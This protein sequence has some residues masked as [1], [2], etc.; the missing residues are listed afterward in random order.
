ML[1]D[2]Y[3]INIM[4]INNQK[5]KSLVLL[6]LIGSTSAKK[7]N[8]SEITLNSLPQMET[9][10]TKRGNDSSQ[11]LIYAGMPISLMSYSLDKPV[12]ENAGNCTLGF[13]INGVAL[14]DWC[15]AVGNSF[16]TSARCC[17]KH[18]HCFSFTVLSPNEK[19]INV[20]KVQQS[21]YIDTSGWKRINFD[22]LRMSL[23]YLEED[24]NKVRITPYVMGGDEDFYP[25]IGLGS[26]TI[27]SQVCAYGAGSGYLCGKLIEI[28]SS[29]EFIKEG[30]NEN[31]TFV[32]NKVDLGEGHG[33]DSERD[34]GGPVYV[35]NTIG[36]T[37]VAQALGYISGVD[38]SDL[39]HKIFYYTPLS[40]FFNYA[41]EL[42]DA[43]GECE[44][45]LMTYN[46][47]HAQ[48][49]DQLIAQM[50]IPVKK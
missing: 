14:S 38:Y 44:I 30:Y 45:E 5:V 40:A 22:Y 17:Q 7:G 23:P 1:T 20:G 42:N 35:A 8:Q 15:S 9:N 12:D 27:G 6:S 2:M 32:V 46:E 39:N 37:T 25:V 28:G 16:I 34:L 26:V 19:E 4:K 49:Y 11:T 43:W 13:A 33:F 36:D 50:E 48:Q 31:F 21:T 3:K 41:K 29:W 18:N 47:T 24:R 10:L